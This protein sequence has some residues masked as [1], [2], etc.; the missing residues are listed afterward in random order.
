MD[1]AALFEE[2]KTLARSRVT[3]A[4][5]PDAKVDLT[6]QVMGEV[7]DIQVMKLFVGRVGGHGH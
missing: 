5:D 1:R 3:G 4:M 6:K 7:L 2:A